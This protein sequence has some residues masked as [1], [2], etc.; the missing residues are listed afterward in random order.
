MHKKDPVKEATIFLGL[1]L[2]FSYFVFWGP[3]VFLKIPAVSFVKDAAPTPV[4]AMIM[5]ILG[6]F[7]PSLTGLGLTRVYE[8]KTGIKTLGKRLIQFNLG[9]RNY[10]AAVIFVLFIAGSQLVI[11]RIG[12]NH[13]DFS[14][15]I[16]QAGSILPLLILGPLSEEIG[17]RGFALD[18]LQTRWNAITSSLIIGVV[19]SFWHLPLFFM[20]GTSQHELGIP[21]AGFL[22]SLTSTSVL[23]TWLHNRARGSIWMAVFFHWIYTYFAQVVSTGVTRSA[24]YNGLEFVPPIILVL[25]IVWVWKTEFFKRP[26]PVVNALP[27]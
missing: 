11:D 6:G 26:L 1:L 27:K 4:W 23:Y 15:F 2:C 24:V 8:G 19:W 13:F 9:W 10:L 18:R 20:I 3:L 5:F 25:L 12:G 22:L 14:I 7:V 17:W 21:F 16:A